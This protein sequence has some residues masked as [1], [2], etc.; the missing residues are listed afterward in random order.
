MRLSYHTIIVPD[1]PNPG[2]HLLY[3]T[4]T[5]ALVKVGSELRDAIDSYEN[6]DPNQAGHL[7]DDMRQLHQMGLLVR[8]DQEESKLLRDHL[9]QIKYAHHPSCLVVTVLTTYGCNFKCTYCFEESSRTSVKLSTT[10]QQK[11]IRWLKYKMRELGYRS[12]YINYYGGEPLLNQPAI[13]QIS[14]EMKQWCQENGLGFSMALQ[15]NGYLLTPSVVEKFKSLNLESV[16]ISVDGVGE[17][18]DSKRPLRGGGGTFQR[19]MDNIVACADMIPIGISI[20]YE[21]GDVEPI[22]KLLDYFDELKILQKLGRIITS[23][24]TPTLG[25]KEDPT[26]I[27]GS[28][29]MCN[30]QDAVLAEATRKIDEMLLA[31]GIGKTKS[32]MSINVCPLT[33]E[34]GGVT[35]DQEGYLYKCNSLLG[36]PEYSVGHVDD[37]KYN[38]VGNQFRDLDVWRQCPVDCTYLPMCSGGCR[39]MSFVG[40]D[41]NFLVASCKKPY[42][43]AMAAEFIKQDYDRMMSAKPVS[44]T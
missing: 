38:A 34:N 14:G 40:G 17:D 18:H 5:Q 9:Q 3:S 32:G 24:I 25:S 28:D 36:H 7:Q 15:T 26:A 35:I 19:I 11:V 13:Q 41:K 30:S 6:F 37:M 1:Y 21:K 4:R 2:D 10:N 8:D 22:R 29:C 27:R 16:R 42:L 31:K 43:N 44:V 12:L 20:G 33:R 23:P 39:L